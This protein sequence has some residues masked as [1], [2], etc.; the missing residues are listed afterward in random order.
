MP[1]KN[2]INSKSKSWNELIKREDLMISEL[3]LSALSSWV[4]DCFDSYAEI[5]EDLL[6]KISNASSEDYELVHDCAV[7]IF[8]HLDHI[9]SHIKDAEKGFS[10]LLRSLALKAEKDQRE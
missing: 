3:E 2:D 6:P 4:M 8:S 7:E 9:K 1:F 10:A 5:Y